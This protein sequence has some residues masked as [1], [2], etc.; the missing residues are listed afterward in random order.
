MSLQDFMTHVEVVGEAVSLEDFYF[1][2]VGEGQF[3]YGDNPK[4][5]IELRKGSGIWAIG[6]LDTGAGLQYLATFPSASSRLEVLMREGPQLVS[7]LRS[8]II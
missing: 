8:D 7:A 1:S 6:I 3:L 2:L 4:Y 5:S